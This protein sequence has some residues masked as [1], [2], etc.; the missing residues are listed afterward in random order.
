M[1]LHAHLKPYSALSHIVCQLHC[2]KAACAAVQSYSPRIAL[3]AE[4]WTKSSLIN[5]RP[6]YIPQLSLD[7]MHHDH[8][9]A[10]QPSFC[11]LVMQ[12]I[13]HAEQGSGL[14]DQTN[15]CASLFRQLTSLNSAVGALTVSP[16]VV[17]IKFRLFLHNMDYM[18]IGPG[19]LCSNSCLFFFSFILPF[20][21]YFAFY[22]TNFA[23]N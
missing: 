7:V 3:S 19:R 21:T 6:I 2:R 13:P 10:I 23:L 11:A 12:Y 16:E 17:C 20:S 22:S 8:Q 4:C 5:Y 9:R 15:L 14:R 1:C 18:Y